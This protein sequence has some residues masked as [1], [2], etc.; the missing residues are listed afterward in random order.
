MSLAQGRGT[1]PLD[2]LRYIEYERRLEKLRQARAKRL[3]PSTPSPFLYLTRRELTLFFLLQP[4]K[5]SVLSRTTP[6]PPTS[7]N[8]TASP[9]DAFPNPSLSGTPSSP[10]PS[11]KPLPSSFPPPSL[12]LS[13]C[14][15]RTPRSGSWRVSGRVREIGREWEVET[16]RPRG[17]FA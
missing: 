17:S 2:Y 6:S 14:T 4:V 1:K 8:S 12:P 15:R 13:P 16:R 7:L 9:S 10:T 11:P 5:R 3:G